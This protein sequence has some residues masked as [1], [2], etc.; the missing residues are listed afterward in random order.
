VFKGNGLFVG[1]IMLLSLGV[2]GNTGQ[3]VMAQTTLSLTIPPIR[4][5]DF[6]YLEIPFFLKLPFKSR[7]NDF[8]ARLFIAPYLVLNSPMNQASS[9]SNWIYKQGWVLGMGLEIYF[10]PQA[11]RPRPPKKV[12]IKFF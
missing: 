6:T 10:K 3:K 1:I 9:S 12:K 4:I 8:F 5:F 2:I 7:H 11:S